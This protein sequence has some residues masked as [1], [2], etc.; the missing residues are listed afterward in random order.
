[1]DNHTSPQII[2]ENKRLKKENYDLNKQ[3]EKFKKRELASNSKKTFIYGRQIFLGSRLN[4]SINIFLGE[5]RKGV[6]KSESIGNV[7]THTLWRFTRLGILTLLLALIPICILIIQTLLL[8][9]QNDKLE[10]QNKKIAVQNQLADGQRRSSYVFLLGNITEKMNTELNGKENRE[11]SRE[12]SGQIVALSHS[13]TPYR[14]L[15]EDGKLS[16]YYS[17]ERTQLLI[18][19]IELN[20]GKETNSYIFERGNFDNLYLSNYTIGDFNSKSFKTK[21]S[22]FTNV[23]FNYCSIEFMTFVDSKRFDQFTIRDCI[24]NKL[25]V[26]GQDSK[27]EKLALQIDNSYIDFAS[28]TQS[29]T[30]RIKLNNNVINCG[31]FFASKDISIFQGLYTNT[32]IKC[33][34]TISISECIVDSRYDMKFLHYTDEV[35]VTEQLS[36]IKPSRTR[37]MPYSNK[38]NILFHNSI[39]IMADEMS[40][41]AEFDSLTQKDS[42]SMLGIT[43]LDRIAIGVNLSCKKKYKCKYNIPSKLSS[44]RTKSKFKTMETLTFDIHEKTYSLELPTVSVY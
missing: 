13:L 36:N 11:L 8:D 18:T 7:I 5:A 17:P 25:I 4:D 21:N 32:L 14:F 28:I 29:N 3:L 16:D 26:R 24:I 40:I 35:G 6:F 33:D 22:S 44:V 23:N 12:L 9:L 37:I 34:S 31:H 1:M 27:G 15:L 43:N 30:S 42:T 41:K 38:E 2:V 39:Y 19:L 20:L 10:V